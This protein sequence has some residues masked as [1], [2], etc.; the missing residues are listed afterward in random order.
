MADYLPRTVAPI[1]SKVVLGA[2][3]ALVSSRFA[4]LNARNV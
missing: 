1:T 3:L 4:K 2:Q